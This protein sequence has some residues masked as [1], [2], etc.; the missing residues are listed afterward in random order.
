M[1]LP[2][3]WGWVNLNRMHHTKFLLRQIE[4]TVY[5]SVSEIVWTWPQIVKATCRLSMRARIDDCHWRLNSITTTK[6]LHQQ[7][8]KLIS[9]TL[10]TT[11]Q[12]I[13]NWVSN[14]P[15]RLLTWLKPKQ[16]LLSFGH[17]M[18]RIRAEDIVLLYLA[19]R[20]SLVKSSYHISPGISNQHAPL[21]IRG[22][23][24]NALMA[25]FDYRRHIRKYFTKDFQIPWLSSMYNVLMCLYCWTLDLTCH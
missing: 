12:S 17:S 20:P 24:F 6:K 14:F 21:L 3:S 13:A 16:A 25:L 23:V 11:L 22:K 15:S 2:F 7:L 5:F 10:L 19:L 4:Y 18:K 1:A 9:T 8:H